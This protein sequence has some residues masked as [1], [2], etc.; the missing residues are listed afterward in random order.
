MVIDPAHYGSLPR[1]ERTRAPEIATP[2][3]ELMPGPGVGLHYAIP[4]VQM[5]RLAMYEE[6]ACVAAV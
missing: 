5:R 2:V 4:E 6:V 1:R 3:A